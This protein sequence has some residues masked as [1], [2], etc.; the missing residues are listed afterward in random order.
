MRPREL[1]LT[2]AYPIRHDRDA[3][4]RLIAE[5]AGIEAAGPVV[6]LGLYVAERPGGMAAEGDRHAL[7][8]FTLPRDVPWPDLMD[9][10]LERIINAEHSRLKR[11]LDI[12]RRFAD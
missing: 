6:K 1:L 4:V 11:S 5:M 3:Q 7:P 10:L 2:T 12:H 8:L 9:P